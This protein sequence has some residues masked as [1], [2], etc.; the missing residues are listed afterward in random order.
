M[1]LVL[2]VEGRLDGETVRSVELCRDDGSASVAR[3]EALGLRL[4]DANVILSRLQTELVASQVGQLS[5]ES[6][7][8]R[9]CE[10]AP[11]SW[12]V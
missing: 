9:R 5:R 7:A 10:A 3:P 2:R 11:I 6:A 4:A 1:A 12:S 8:C